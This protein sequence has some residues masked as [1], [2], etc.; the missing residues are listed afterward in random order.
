M[1][2]SPETGK[3]DCHVIDIVDALDRVSGIASIPHL[4]GLDPSE[5][6]DGITVC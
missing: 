1:R 2:M 6:V 3:E 4:F 5:V